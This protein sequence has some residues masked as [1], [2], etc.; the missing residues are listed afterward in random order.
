MATKARSPNYPGF[1]LKESLELVAKVYS[2]ERRASVPDTSVARALGYTSMSG[3]ARVKIATLRKYGL[4]D[5]VK[6]SYR[7]SDLAMRILFPERDDDRWAAISDAADRPEVFRDLEER[8]EG[9]DHTLTNLLV[10]RGFTPDGA[11]QAVASFRETKAYL[12]AESGVYDA[13]DEEEP[14][15]IETPPQRG[16]DKLDLRVKGYVGGTAASAPDL[17]FMLPD[18]IYAYIEFK[19]GRPTSRSLD[20][21]ARYLD[22]AKESV[23]A[24]ETAAGSSLS[25]PSAPPLPD[26]RSLSSSQD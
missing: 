10:Q 8:A 1:G 24:T 18:G 12:K 14:E 17:A 21:L 4:L 2:H 6:G 11:K 19:G 15:V 23:L 16:G 13:P 25:G 5:E 7:V 22:L 3:R 9:S 26:E 20:M